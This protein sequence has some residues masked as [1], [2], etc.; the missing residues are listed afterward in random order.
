[1][2]LLLNG[3]FGIGKTTLARLLK[4]RLPHSVIYDPELLGMTMQRALRLVGVRVDDFQD[5]WLWRRLTIV[6]LR[7]ARLTSLHVIVPMAISNRDYLR[8]LQRIGLIHVCLVAPVEEVHARLRARGA[9]S[10]WEFRRAAECC[11]VHRGEEFAMHVAADSSP[12]Q[13][14]DE[15][16]QLI[17]GT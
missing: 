1:V 10:E 12:D 3:A 14:A 8:E 11:D 5:L 9:A 6:A 4:Q 7:V 15:L 17:T 13:I 16:L 2:I